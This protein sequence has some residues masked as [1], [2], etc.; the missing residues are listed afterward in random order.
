F[1]F[2]A[3]D[4]IRDR[5]VTGVQTCALPILSRSLSLPLS[6]LLSPPRSLSLLRSRPLSEVRTL[7]DESVTMA[8]SLRLSLPSPSVLRRTGARS[9]ERRAGKGGGGRRA[10]SGRRSS[11]W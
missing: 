5:T 8:R 4:G 3:E 1:F 9:E 2:H 6:P 11:V 7:P 10:R